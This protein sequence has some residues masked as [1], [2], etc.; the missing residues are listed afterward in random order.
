MET[1]TLIRDMKQSQHKPGFSTGRRLDLTPTCKNIKEVTL[2]IHTTEKIN[3]T[4]S[5]LVK[6]SHTPTE[7]WGHSQT[8]SKVVRLPLTDSLLR[9]LSASRSDLS[10]NSPCTDTNLLHLAHQGIGHAG[11]LTWQ[12]H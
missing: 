4:Q 9:N 10:I 2:M 7:C 5:R 6:F 12:Y 3:Q 8:A 11:E 1:D